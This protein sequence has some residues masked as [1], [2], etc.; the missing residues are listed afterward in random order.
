MKKTAAMVLAGCLLGTAAPGQAKETLTQALIRAERTRIL[1]KI[2]PLYY[3][4]GQELGYTPQQINTAFRSQW[5]AF[6]NGQPPPQSFPLQ[7]AQ[8]QAGD[9]ASE[10]GDAAAPPNAGGPP[11]SPGPLSS[12]PLS[13]SDLRPQPN[14]PPHPGGAAK[15]RDLDPEVAALR[16]RHGFDRGEFEKD[17][18]DDDAQPFSL[19][20]LDPREMEKIWQQEGQEKQVPDLSQ[21]FFDYLTH[22][23]D[24]TENGFGRFVRQIR[25]GGEKMRRLPYPWLERNRPP[26][27]NGAPAPEDEGEEGGEGKERSALS[28]PG[29]IQPGRSM[30]D[31]PPGS[32][33][34][35]QAKPDAK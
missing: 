1:Q 30:N 11:F 35:A 7:N 20:R 27:K 29:E 13:G 26:Q 34:P 28:L 33:G 25:K 2:F 10:E 21:K 12:L 8:A 5:T 24:G 32:L 31:I 18:G 6:A 17:D 15:E 19:P 22:R 23:Q 16:Q 3:S 4:Y 9:E 14:R